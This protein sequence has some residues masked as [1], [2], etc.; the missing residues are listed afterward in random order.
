MYLPKIVKNA[1]EKQFVN[2]AIALI[3]YGAYYGVTNK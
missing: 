3:A 1:F 2:Y